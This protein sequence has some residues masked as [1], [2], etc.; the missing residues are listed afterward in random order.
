MSQQIFMDKCRI[1]RMEVF[2]NE[3]TINDHVSVGMRMPSGEYERPIP[4]KRLYWT[5]P[6]NVSSI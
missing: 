3:R 6:G 4:G 2:M 1:Y 5:N